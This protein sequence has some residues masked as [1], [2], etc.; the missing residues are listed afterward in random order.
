MYPDVTP[1]KS[2]AG[3]PFEIRDEKACKAI[4]RF[5]LMRLLLHETATD[6][7]DVVQSWQDRTP[8]FYIDVAT[9]TEDR[10]IIMTSERF[11]KVR[12]HIL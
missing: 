11:Y 3:V 1:A 8:A 4:A 6:M 12:G 9:T 2:K 7:A 10:P 5:L